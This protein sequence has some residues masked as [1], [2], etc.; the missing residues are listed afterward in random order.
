MLFQCFINPSNQRDKYTKLTEE[1]DE[2]RG[3]SKLKK[4]EK[5][6]LHIHGGKLVIHSPLFLSP[7]GHKRIKEEWEE[8]K[9]GGI[10]SIGEN[11]GGE[12]PLRL[13]RQTIPRHAAITPDPSPGR[14][15]PEGQSSLVRRRSPLLTMS[16]FSFSFPFPFPS[17]S[18]FISHIPLTFPHFLF[19]FPF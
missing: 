6:K 13:L 19:P 1:G 11:A 10:G 18:N 7:L 3:L 8:L 2:W 15:S 5:K 12:I 14:L 9:E 16:L 4:K 17:R